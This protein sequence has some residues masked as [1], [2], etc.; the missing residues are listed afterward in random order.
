MEKHDDQTVMDCPVFFA[1][2]VISG[3]WSMVI[4]YFLSKETLRFSELRR[5]LPNVSQTMLTSQLRGLE[6]YGMVERKV[7]AQVPPKVEY[8]LTGIGR[9]FLP[10]LAALETWAVAY[11]GRRAD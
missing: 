3:K 10:V 7:Y 8:S 6:E 11:K 5:K 2:K 4:I 9:E 1:Q